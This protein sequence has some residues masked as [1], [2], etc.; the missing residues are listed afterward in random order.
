[1]NTRKPFGRKVW[2]TY[3]LDGTSK[4][5][6]LLIVSE[7]MQVYKYL[8]DA[9]FDEFFFLFTVVRIQ[10]FVIFQEFTGKRKNRILRTILQNCLG[11]KKGLNKMAF[12]R[13]NPSLSKNFTSNSGFLPSAKFST[14]WKKKKNVK[15]LK[16]IIACSN[17]TKS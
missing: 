5:W 13:K 2:I 12:N 6:T 7:K 11:W 8:T 14:K 17:F 3:Y 16:S 15:I 1:M 9:F 10:I 4:N